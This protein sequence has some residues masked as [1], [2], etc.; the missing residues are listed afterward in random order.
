[1]YGRKGKL[2]AFHRHKLG[3]SDED[4]PGEVLLNVV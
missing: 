2:D 1:M 3:K 4:D